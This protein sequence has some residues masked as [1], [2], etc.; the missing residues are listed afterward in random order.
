MDG[1]DLL[2]A[3]P[4]RCPQPSEGALP[5]PCS[6]V[7]AP[8]LHPLC[9]GAVPWCHAMGL[10]HGAMP[11]G[12]AMPTL[13]PLCHRS[14]DSPLQFLAEAAHLPALHRPRPARQP[15][16]GHRL[17]SATPPVARALKLGAHSPGT[18]S[19][20]CQAGVFW[21]PTPLKTHTSAKSHLSVRE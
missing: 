13:C 12:A 8:S 7:S 16:G 9:C 2:G 21:I 1:E 15:G 6:S 3:P 11:W 14:E 10:C 18:R 4:A 20:H 17:V 5:I 19:A